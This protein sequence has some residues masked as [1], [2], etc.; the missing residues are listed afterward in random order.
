[1]PRRKQ[2]TEA[3]LRPE[4]K[5]WVLCISGKN[6]KA[7]SGSNRIPFKSQGDPVTVAENGWQ[8]Q[9]SEH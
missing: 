2:G 1:M 3:R 6:W 7:F 5:E 8:G 9:M 4:S